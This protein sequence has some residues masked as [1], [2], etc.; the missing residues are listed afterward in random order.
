M[1]QRHLLPIIFQAIMLLIILSALFG[2]SQSISKAPE[3][4]L[5]GAIRWD[6]WHTPAQLLTG[7]DPVKSVER[8]LSPKR[9]HFRVP[10]FGKIISDSV[11]KIDGYTSKIMDE[12]IKY[13]MNGGLDYWAFLLY[14]PNSSMSQGLAHYLSSKKRSAINFCAIAQPDNLCFDEKSGNGETRL[15]K[16]FKEPGYQ[17]VAGDRPLIY[18]FRPE[19]EW[20][21]KIGG[22]DKTRKLIDA[23]RMESIKAHCGNPYV[24]VM[25]FN[26]EHAK[27]MADI[28]GAEAISDYAIWGSGGLNGTP[29]SELTAATR[30]VWTRSESTGAQV[31]PLV[32][33]GWDRR[34]RIERPVPWERSYQKPYVGMEKYFSLPTPEELAAHLKDAITWTKS[35]KQ[36]CP[37]KTVLVYAWNEHDE[38]GWLCPT[39]DKNNQPDDSRLKALNKVIHSL[40]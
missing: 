32:M 3:R 14:D 2:C 26:V 37:A 12:E 4:I 8:S 23:F 16:L 11:I 17:K 30:N 36:V 13:A 29:Y 25:H 21:E 10:F 24:V 33:S 5:V 20:V 15:L 39:L 31:V 9:Y 1:N 27:K 35:R 40:N 34:P 6:A 38:G 18:I 7:E 22:L 19:D 28:L